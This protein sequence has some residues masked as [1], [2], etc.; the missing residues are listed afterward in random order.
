ME[1][2]AN[3]HQIQFLQNTAR[4]ASFGQV[5]DKDGKLSSLHTVPYND[6]NKN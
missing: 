1:N 6:Q 3:G 2:Q 5:R 4:P